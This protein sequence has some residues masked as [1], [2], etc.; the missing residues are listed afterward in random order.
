MEENHS[1]QMVNK[2]TAPEYG[3]VLCIWSGTLRELQILIAAL[4]NIIKY[5]HLNIDTV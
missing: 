1:Y 2:R 3:S 4:F 5:M